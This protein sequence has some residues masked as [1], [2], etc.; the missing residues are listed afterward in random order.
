MRVAVDCRRPIWIARNTKK[1]IIKQPIWYLPTWYLKDRYYVSTYYPFEKLLLL[2]HVPV[3]IFL[4]NKKKTH[5]DPN[6]YFKFRYILALINTLT[7]PGASRD[8][9]SNQDTKF[10]KW[11]I[12]VISTFPQRKIFMRARAAWNVWHVYKVP[13]H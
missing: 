4:Q 3:Y 11:N 13:T 2:Y 5:F 10:Q 8:G 6:P 1:K 12:V 9:K 7:S